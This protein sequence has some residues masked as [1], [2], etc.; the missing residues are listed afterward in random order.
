[1]YSKLVVQD[2]GSVHGLADSSTEIGISMQVQN[3]NLVFCFH[4]CHLK[5]HE[6]ITS[7][8]GGW[9]NNRAECA[10]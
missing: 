4:F 1:M 7:S 8:P 3:S 6:S 5:R 10:Y 9:L 2:T